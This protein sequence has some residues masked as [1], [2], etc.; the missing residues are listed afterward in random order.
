M[1]AF[2]C[3]ILYIV[4]VSVY[5]LNSALCFY[6]DLRILSFEKTN[7]VSTYTKYQHSKI[8]ILKIYEKSFPLVCLNVVCMTPLCIY[9]LYIMQRFSVVLPFPLFVTFILSV[10]C[11]EI[12][13]YSAHRLLHHKYVYSLIHKKH[14]YFKSPVG[15]SSFYMTPLDYIFG[16][17]IPL[18]LAPVLFNIPFWLYAIYMSVGLTNTI[19]ISHSG[20]NWSN[21]PNPGTQDH[22]IHHQKTYYNY[23]FLGFMDV[24]CKTKYLH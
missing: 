23:G 19:L 1:D 10:C 7:S 16:N 5:F 13:F 22:D 14:H 4:F 24:L 8:P 12:L 2:E 9:I 15:F 21:K 3:C 6:L 17:I 18:G 11:S 20:I